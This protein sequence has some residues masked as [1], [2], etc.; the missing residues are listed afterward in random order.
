MLLVAV[1]VRYSLV[2]TCQKVV[3]TTIGHYSLGVADKV[4]R[5]RDMD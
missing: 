2:R 5:E 1:S 4:I 3:T